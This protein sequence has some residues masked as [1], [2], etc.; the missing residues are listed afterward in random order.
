MNSFTKKERICSKKDIGT[1][2]KDG[3]SLFRHPFKIIFKKNVLLYDRILI[4]VPKREFKKAVERN[5]I[6]RRIRESFRTSKL[7][8]AESQYFDIVFIY[9]GG[10]ILTYNQINEK[11]RECMERIKKSN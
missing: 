1:L 5:L 8:Y 9:I 2:F 4:S 7:L 10:E 6:K 11:V 3:D